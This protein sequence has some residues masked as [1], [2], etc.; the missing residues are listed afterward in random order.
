MHQITVILNGSPDPSHFIFEIN[1]GKRR[2]RQRTTS[3]SICFESIWKFIIQ[4]ISRSMSDPTLFDT[5]LK[6]KMDSTLP[7]K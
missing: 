2:I 5:D 1:V 6:N 3:S 7:L 4:F